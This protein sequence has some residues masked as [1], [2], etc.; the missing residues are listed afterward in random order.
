M[1]SRSRPSRSRT[2]RGAG[3]GIGPRDAASVRTNLAGGSGDDLLRGG[4]GADDL[5]GA[6]GNDELYGGPGAD[7]LAGR[8][9][10]DR[11][12]GGPGG[13]ELVGGGGLH[14]T[15]SYADRVAGVRVSIGSGGGDD[16]GPEDYSP[17]GAD[18]V[19]SDVEQ[20]IGGAGADL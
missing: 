6:G 5:D 17:S 14:D 1:R 9:G 16:G 12:D 3:A 2:A 15:V 20:V 13:D 10:T 11:L 4:I 8:N 19:A 7:A 18:T